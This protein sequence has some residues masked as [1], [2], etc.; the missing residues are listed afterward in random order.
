VNGVDIEPGADARRE[1]ALCCRI[2]GHSG[3]P[4]EALL[5]AALARAQ[6]TAL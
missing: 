5:V 4:P 2:Y 6:P 3:V 1:Y